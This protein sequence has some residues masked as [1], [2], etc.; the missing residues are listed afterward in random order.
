MT[1]LVSFERAAY[2]RAPDRRALLYTALRA[3]VTGSLVEN[4]AQPD[5]KP[6]ADATM[7]P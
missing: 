3:F 1:D 6:A 7:R 4:A 5:S 2:S